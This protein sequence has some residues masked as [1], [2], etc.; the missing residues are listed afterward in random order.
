MELM[1]RNGDGLGDG[2]GVCLFSRNEDKEG[3][4]AAAGVVQN[5]A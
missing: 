4:E 2:G 3:G 5:W 1:F